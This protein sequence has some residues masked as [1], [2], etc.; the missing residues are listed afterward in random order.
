MGKGIDLVFQNDIL[1]KIILHANQFSETKFAF[2]DRCYFEIEHEGQLV[3]PVGPVRKS[4]KYYVNTAGD[5][6]KTHVYAYPHLLV[7]VIPGS[8]L[9]STVTLF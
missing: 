3:T 1:T 2:Y 4:E 8:D 7:E 9:V 6:S 5:G